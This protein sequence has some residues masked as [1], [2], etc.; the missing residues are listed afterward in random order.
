MPSLHCRTSYPFSGSETGLPKR[1]NLP[2]EERIT[3]VT[4]VLEQILS[5]QES[6]ALSWLRAPWRTG[7]NGFLHSGSDH[8]IFH[9]RHIYHMIGGTLGEPIGVGD[10]VPRGE[11]LPFNAL[12]RLAVRRALTAF[13][14]HILGT[15][16]TVFT[17]STTVVAYI[18]RQGGTH[19]DRP[20]CLGTIRSSFPT[21][22]LFGVSCES[23][24]SMSADARRQSTVAIYDS[25]LQKF[26]EWCRTRQVMPTK[27]A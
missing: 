7:A 21:E 12:E 27:A 22:R 25:R 14:Q 26:G 11:V 3:A 17:D 10:L 24:V 19:A 20:G 16:T 9:N 5:S 4:T 2:T 15:R 1:N 13:R 6:P 23:V 18:N 8:N